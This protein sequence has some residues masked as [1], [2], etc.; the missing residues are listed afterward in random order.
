MNTIIQSLEILKR[1][2]EQWISYLHGQKYEELSHL[3]ERPRLKGKLLRVVSL[4]YNVIKDIKISNELPCES[5]E[6]LMLAGTQ[7][8][9]SALKGLMSSLKSN[10]RSI[11]CIA[12]EDKIEKKMFILA[13]LNQLSFQ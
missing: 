8:Q 4:Y 1:E 13:F 9:K 7:N 6:F 10:K 11:V 5:H 3:Q 2:P 12:P